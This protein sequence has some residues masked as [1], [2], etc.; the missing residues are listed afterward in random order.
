[1]NISKSEQQ[2][3]EF[4]WQ[5]NPLTVGQVIERVQASTDWH[6]NTIKTMLTRLSNKGAVERNKDGKRFFYSPSVT[7]EEL[8]AEETEGFLS[9][10]FDGKMAP[11]LAHFADN[12][13]VSKAELAE[14]EAIVAKLKNDN[15]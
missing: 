15:G 12:Q 1:V 2:L 14:I 5:E 7:R 13:K 11:L 6:A 8:V 3:L 10:F 4:L 9:R